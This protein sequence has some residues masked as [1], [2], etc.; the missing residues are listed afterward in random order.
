V[1]TLT[2][3][4]PK[5][6][7]RPSCKSAALDRGLLSEGKEKGWGELMEEIGG[8]FEGPKDL[9]TSPKHLGGLGQQSR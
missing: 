5:A 7:D 1:K 9:S 6:F 8:F 3:K 4:V 2:I